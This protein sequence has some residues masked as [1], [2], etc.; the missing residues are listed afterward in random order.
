MMDS[1][2]V[3]ALAIVL[4][5]ACLLHGRYVARYQDESFLV[6]FLYVAR[7]LSTGALATCYWLQILGLAEKD[8]IIPVVR[9][10]GIPAWFVAGVLPALVKPRGHVMAE[11]IVHTV[12]EKFRQ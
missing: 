6:N 8:E 12:R 9:G 10:I 3:W 1:F 7:G 11:D 2:L 4:T 5:A